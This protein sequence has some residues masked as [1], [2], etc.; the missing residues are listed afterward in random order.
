MRL[1][2]Q[3]LRAFVLLVSLPAATF[4]Q[5][6]IGGVVKDNTGAVLP[7][8]TVEASSPVLIE[9][10]RTATT[11]GNGRYRIEN[12]Q[13]GPYTVTFTLQGFSTVKHENLTISG[14]GVTTVDADMKVGGVAETITVSAEAP[15][16]DVQSTKRELTLDNET[17][18][19]LPS[20]RSYSY[21]L[22]TVPGMTS[23]ITD[24][25]T[26]PVFAIFPVHGGRG[27]ESRLTVEGMNI[28]NPPGGNQPPNYTADIGNAAEVTV[29]TS[30]GLGESETAGVQM[31]IVPKTGGNR[32]SGLVAL[33]GFSKGMQSDN[34][35]DEL[36]NKGAGTP[37][38]TYH[39]YDF[40]IAAGGP[41]VKDRLWYYMS[42]REQGSRRNIL[43]LYY[44]K[45]A[46]DA[47]QWYYNPDFSRPA[48]Y[49]RMWE[50]YTPRITWQ[51][52][53][54][55]KLTLSWDEQPVCRTCSGTANFSG[56][57][58]PNVAP[59]AD[60]HGEFSPQRV[61]TARWTNPW[62]NKLLLEAGLGNTYYQW[63]VRELDPNPGHDLV[64]V[65]DNATIINDA[66]AIAAITSRSQNWLV[67]KTDGANWFTYASYITGS[68]SMKFGYQGNWW[69]DDRG[70]H[71]N[72]QSLQYTLDGG[73]RAADGTFIPSHPTTITEYANP[74]F[75]NAR[76]AMASFF[77]Q[78]QWTLKRLTLQ[79][80]VR[81]D[82]P[83]S[84]F[85][86]VTQPQGRFFPGV[87]FDEQPG[88]TGYNDITPR[89]GAAY[90]V[91]G[92]GKTALKVNL[93]KYLQG[94]SVGNLLS[95]ANPSLRIP[96]GAGA[97]FFNPSVTRSWTDAN[98]DF[99][100]DCDLSNP[101]AQN[102]AGATPIDPT[103]DSCGQISNLLFGSNQFVGATI[104]PSV[105]HGWGVRPSDWSFGASVQQ[106]IFPRAS[107]EVGYYRRVFTMFTTGGVVTDDLNVGPND[108]TSFSVPVPTD[109]LN[110]L[111]GDTPAAIPGFLN[112]TPEA[113]GRT[114]NL[115]LRSTKDI[116]DDSRVFNGVDVT[117]NVRTLKGVTFTG[118]TS[119]GK[120]T[121]DWC[122]IRA[123]VP[124]NG[125]F[126][127]NPYCHTSSPVQTSFNGQASYVIPKADVLVSGVYRDRVILNGTPNNAST[128]QLGGS[129][130][131]TFRVSTTDPAIVAQIGR[132]LTGV[133]FNANL[134]EPG[135]FYPGRNRQLD[136]S[137]KKI[138]RLGNRRFT[139]GLDIYNVANSNTILFYNTAFIPNVTGYLTPFAYMNP[140]VFRLAAEF[141]W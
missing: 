79:G 11:D 27:V 22:N 134:V 18:R 140:R 7:G 52:S 87:S 32:F 30:G 60:G 83:W 128:D 72:S 8:V 38:P 129:L 88:V 26:G 69:K 120:V 6:A 139:G 21:L 138:V 45:N 2:G 58:S 103:K 37:N 25:N 56:S 61:Q 1:T 113:F 89:M 94:A 121:N 28:S 84:W 82:H 112:K 141:A 23:N 131:A 64:R 41:I 132:S 62:T 49:D 97:G 80:A 109:S 53:Q 67:A 81:Y 74:Y 15:V 122:D 36:K 70:E 124:E 3:I 44:N 126:A 135:T 107:V 117:F 137:L 75:N 101:L 76:A 17:M 99:V 123:A 34:Y 78:D 105:T 127:T 86:A 95:Q 118:G 93:G 19:N 100:P 104:D 29:T 102:L 55:N 9:K 35:T 14:T 116:G 33:S 51:A 12:L 59:D 108:F 92:N 130:P 46:G 66:G 24:V 16:V 31:N 136:L 4:A 68:H 40:N 125:T 110:R 5:S 115:L 98:Q 111:P 106:Q 10:S 50:N 65:V 133:A 119:T 54:K 13:P 90:D 57:P 91:F 73:T 114:Q 43:N 63:G 71:T 39:V 96:G 20:V 85:P 48:Y 47:N 77:A 42:V